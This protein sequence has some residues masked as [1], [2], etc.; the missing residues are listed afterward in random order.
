MPEIP[1]RVLVAVCVHDD[2]PSYC[3]LDCTHKAKNRQRQNVCTLFHERLVQDG[4]EDVGTPHPR[5][6]RCKG[7]QGVLSV[8]D[9]ERWKLERRK[10][11]ELEKE[12]R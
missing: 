8:S 7:C 2:I 10:L 4:C 11:K 6:I 3:H 5:Y 9:V 12:G 1:T